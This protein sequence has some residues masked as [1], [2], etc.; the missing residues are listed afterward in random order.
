MHFNNKKPCQALQFS[1]YISLFHLQETAFFFFF[2]IGLLFLPHCATERSDI[3]SFYCIRFHQTTLRKKIHEWETEVPEIP[4]VPRAIQGVSSGGMEPRPPKSNSRTSAIQSSFLSIAP[5]YLS[6]DHFTTIN[7]FNHKN[8]YSQ[9]MIILIKKTR[10]FL[11]HDVHSVSGVYSHYM[12][13]PIKKTRIFL[14]HDVH[15]VSGI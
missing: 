10:I 3:L 12:I 13:I 2:C 7:P 9:Y 8:I 6:R 4:R 5:L 14:L 11:L 15:S 1:H